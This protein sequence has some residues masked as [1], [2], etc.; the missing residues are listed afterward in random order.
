MKDSFKYSKKRK[1]KD[2]V[3]LLLHGARSL[4][5]GTPLH[6]A[7]LTRSDLRSRRSE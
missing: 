3:G 2:S 4:V 1:T 7:S 6:L 5:E